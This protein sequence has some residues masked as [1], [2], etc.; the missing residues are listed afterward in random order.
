MAIE[1]CVSQYA[2][3]CSFN[4]SVWKLSASSCTNPVVPTRSTSVECSAATAAPVK[5]KK[6]AVRKY[7]PLHLMVARGMCIRAPLGLQLERVEKPIRGAGPGNR[8]QTRL[9]ANF[10]QNA[11]EIHGSLVSPRRAPSPE[12]QFFMGFRGPKAHPD[13]KSTRLNS[14]HL[15][16]S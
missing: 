10:R 3:V 2:S 8:G 15:G 6:S 16:T 14:S 4:L 7:S 9:P 1:A 12:G 11:P 13:R 5:S